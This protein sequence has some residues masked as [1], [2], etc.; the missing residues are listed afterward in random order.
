MRIDDTRGP[1][2]PSGPRG[3]EPTGGIGRWA[4]R[5]VQPGTSR[6]PA[7]SPSGVPPQDALQD[8]VPLRAAMI[9]SATIDNPGVQELES[10]QN[11]LAASDAGIE[12]YVDGVLM[13][14]MLKDVLGGK[15]AP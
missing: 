14:S 10:L 3:P 11:W 1:N 13:S 6:L 5:P 8:R 2:T 4:G 12:T 15:T 7:E 9:E